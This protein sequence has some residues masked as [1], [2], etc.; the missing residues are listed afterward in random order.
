MLRRSKQEYGQKNWPSKTVTSKS[1][2]SESNYGGQQWHRRRHMYVIC[3]I[4]ATVPYMLRP[5][6]SLPVLRNQMSCV[7]HLQR[8]ALLNIVSSFWTYSILTVVWF[9]GE[10]L[11]FWFVYKS[12]LSNYV[13]VVLLGLT[14]LLLIERQR[15]STINA[16]NNVRFSIF[17]Q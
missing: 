16:P 6:P 7:F 5:L 9:S 4:W 8:T 14:H 1:S 10:Y 12:I 2:T 11:I 17:W 3:Q 15:R 13:I